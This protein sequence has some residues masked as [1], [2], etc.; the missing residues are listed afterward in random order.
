[1]T[2]LN[3]W[4]AE[5]LKGVDPRNLRV[6]V[7]VDPRHFDDVLIALR[8]M[9]LRVVSTSFDRFI[10]VVVPDVP[11]IEAIER[12]PGVV[13][14]HYDM[15]RYVKPLPPFIPPS[16]RLKDPLLGEI[17][18]SEIEVPSLK[19]PSLATPFGGLGLPPIKKADVEII[20]NSETYKIIIDVETSLSGKGIKIAVIDTGATPL[21][22]Q[23]LGKKVELY[24]TV[25]EPPFDMQGHGMWCSTQV[26]GK[27]FNTRFGRVQGIAPSADLIHV[28][29]LTTA[30]FGS[31]ASVIKA[32]EIATLK[33]AKV[34]SMSLGGPQQGGV[35]HDPECKVTKILNGM[36]ILVVVAAGNEGPKEWTIASPGVSPWVLTVGAYSPMYNGVAEYSSR[37]P[38]GDYYKSHRSEWEEDYA[39]YGDLLVKPD[40]LAPGG[41]PV[42]GEK[43]ID[44]IY[45][46][47]TGWFDGFYDLFAD[48]FEPMR[49]SSM[50]TPHVAGLMALIAEAVPEVSID[51]IKR[52]IRAV[53][54]VT[55]KSIDY[56]Y[57]LIKLSMFR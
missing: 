52:A 7:E 41:G 29:A 43:P 57:G 40:V 49:G 55:E 2:K 23:L 4:L 21:H 42:K 9:G 56:G 1:M 45:S 39:K 30:G 35:D 33:G 53:S 54:G 5:K 31:S 32:M 16:L 50:A 34:I 26:L 51:V 27:P 13:E 25:P 17:R 14:I 46:G 8:K 10:T 37:G 11:T 3:P 12:I 20:P 24:T 19:L 38:S 6:I 18:I 15:P 48:G 28:K 36:G 44:L 47:C 22:P